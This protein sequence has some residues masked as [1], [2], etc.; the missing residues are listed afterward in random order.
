M[1]IVGLA[2]EADV[3]QATDA[4]GVAALP[5]DGNERLA[6]VA[7]GVGC[8]NTDSSIKPEMRRSRAIKSGRRVVD[9]E[10]VESKIDSSSSEDISMISRGL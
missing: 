6:V 7:L 8:E 10:R 2:V 3:E 9:G 1:T 5:P 4:A